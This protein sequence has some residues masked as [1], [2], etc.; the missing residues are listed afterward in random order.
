MGPCKFG[1]ARAGAG[2]AAVTVFWPD[3]GARLVYFEKG[4]P[5]RSDRPQADGGGTLSFDRKA[6][7]FVLTIGDERFEIPEAVIS[8][9]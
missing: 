1:V 3:G 5:V 2:S 7:L 9:G 6:D 4:E 8:G